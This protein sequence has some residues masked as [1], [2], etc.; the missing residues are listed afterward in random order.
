[1]F[2]DVVRN[3]RNP[4]QL[5]AF[6]EWNIAK[7]Q[8]IRLP[9]FFDKMHPVNAEEGQHAEVMVTGILVK[10]GR[11]TCVFIR[12]P[13]E[14]DIPVV[15]DGFDCT[16]SECMTNSFS[17]IPDWDRPGRNHCVLITPGSLEHVLPVYYP[18]WHENVFPG[19][20]AGTGWVRLH[21]KS[22]ERRQLYRLE[23]VRELACLYV[24]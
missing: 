2:V 9:A 5:M 20:V 13:T 12:C 22:T 7:G 24:S 18:D 17:H 11:P 4:Q 3:Q 8:K 6:V 16:G 10:K 1:M 21:P 23:G 19:R 14:Q 15:Y